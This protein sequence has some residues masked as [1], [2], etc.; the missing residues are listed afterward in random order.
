M[1]PIIS[2]TRLAEY[3]TETLPWAHGHQ[4]KA[5]TTF[6]D[7]IF[8]TQTGNQAQLARTQGKQEAALKRLSRLLH[9]ERLDP[10]DLAEGVLYQALRQ[11]PKHG[12]VRLTIDW[13]T[14]DEQHLLVISLVVGRR[15]TPIYWRAY[16]QRRLKGRT[17]RYEMAVL[18]R[19]FKLIFSHVA[20]GRIRLTADRGFADTELFSLLDQWR[21]R[22]IIRVRGNVKVR[23]EGDWIKLR[24]LRFLGNE[25]RRTLG[26]IE[27]CESSPQQLFLTM[28]R[29]R[30]KNGRW[31]IW[32]LISNCSLRAGRMAAEYGFRFDCEEGFR[33]AKWWLGFKQARI[34]DIAAWSR[35]FALFAIA[36]LAL[37]TLGMAI[38]IAD[39]V[40][41]R[42]LLRRVISRR[43]G[44]CELSLMAAM[45]A[46]LQRDRTLLEALSPAVK[47][48]LEASLH[49]VS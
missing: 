16:D 17:R 38:L 24:H 27:Y 13:T 22:F 36:L 14:E 28:S 43:K 3:I 8:E 5:I 40:K 45:L 34:R 49:N 39:P 6:V 10:H 35:L 30:G 47:F 37:L 48:N 21:I 1:N 11:V 29:A 15:A 31:G 7:A 32:Y 46:L 20:P 19:A 12:R 26:R 33:D 2:S 4:V 44:R 41:A 42:I 23:R 25:R 9:N 18:K